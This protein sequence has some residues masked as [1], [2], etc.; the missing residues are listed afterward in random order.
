MIVAIA[1]LLTVRPVSVLVVP[2]VV[3]LIHQLQHHPLQ[4][5]QLQLHLHLTVMNLKLT[6]TLVSVLIAITVVPNVQMSIAKNAVEK[7]VVIAVLLLRPVIIL[8]VKSVLELNVQSVAHHLLL[9]LHLL[10]LY[11]LHLLLHLL[12]QP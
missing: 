5:Y 12:H 6:V 10:Q 3:Y 7:N 2:I 9:L 1:S 11:L 8:T 4:L